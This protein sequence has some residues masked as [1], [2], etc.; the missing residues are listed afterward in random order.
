MAIIGEAWKAEPE[1]RLGQLIIAWAGV[2]W[3]K[4][5]AGAM[6]SRRRILDELFFI[7]DADLAAGLFLY[8]TRERGPDGG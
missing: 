5:D 3:G 4:G 7:E 8:S 6:E 2:T 1:M